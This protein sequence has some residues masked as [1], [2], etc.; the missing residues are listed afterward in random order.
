[1]Q[2]RLTRSHTSS[3]RCHIQTVFRLEQ[4]YMAGGKV[5][6]VSELERIRVSMCPL[7]D[8]KTSA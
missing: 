1:M 8:T 4:D 6:K 2:P 3:T 7:R 5:G